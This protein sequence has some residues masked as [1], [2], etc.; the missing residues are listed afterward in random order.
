MRN[1]KRP[2]A[3]TSELAVSCDQAF[4]WVCSAFGKGLNEFVSS[5][6]KPPPSCLNC[7]HALYPLSSTGPKPAAPVDP[8][9]ATPSVPPLKSSD[10]WVSDSTPAPDP[11]SSTAARPKT[12]NTGDLEGSSSSPALCFSLNSFK[13]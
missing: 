7:Q 9:G 11:W 13:N 3:D 5:V 4:L 2:S 6:I 12:S 8:W 10:P 1:V